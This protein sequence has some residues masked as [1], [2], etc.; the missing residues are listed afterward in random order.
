MTGP[1]MLGGIYAI[2]SLRGVTK[3]SDL[4]A[5]VEEVKG[6]GYVPSVH[7][8]EHPVTGAPDSM[9]CGYYKLWKN[10]KL[11]GLTVPEFSG[12]EGRD[13]VKAAGGAYEV[14]EGKHYEVQVVINLVGGKTLAPNANDQRFVVDGWAIGE[15][16]L[17]LLKYLGLAVSTV[18]QLSTGVYRHL[19]ES[20]QTLSPHTVL[21]QPLRAS[22][23]PGDRLRLS[24]AGAAWPAIGV[25]PGTPDH[26]AGAPSPDHRVVTM[27]LELTG[28]RLRLIPLHS[29]DPV[30]ASASGS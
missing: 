16:G 24:I 30:E 10:G 3:A 21:L 2:A 4:A 11:A 23:R 6:K 20:A 8:H 7:G 19:G 14:L 22:L 28:S 13:A 26:P 9:G 15:F 25:N 12:D 18:E 5:I 27:M 1:K 17:D 29:S